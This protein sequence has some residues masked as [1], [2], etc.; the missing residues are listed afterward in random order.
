MNAIEDD[1][2]AIF[3]A[4]LE[5]TP[6]GRRNQLDAACG[7]NAELRARVDQL[8]DA[9]QAMG[10]IHGGLPVE[11]ATIQQRLEEGKGTLIGPYKLLE[12]IGEGGFGVVFLAEQER[13]VR[14]RV[15]L[16]IVKPGMDT[17]QVIARFEAERQALAMMDHPNI[18]KVLDAGTTVDRSLREGHG[19]RSEPATVETGRPYFVMELVKG[20]PITKYCD[21]HQHTIHQRVELFI[22]ICDGVQHAHQKGVIHRD[23]KPSNILV[24]EYDDRPVPKVIDFGV[25]KALSQSLTEKTMFTQFGQ[26]V[27][28]LDYMSPEQAKLNQLDVDTR[29][30]IYSL[31]VV[32]YELL[33]GLT[34][35]DKARLQSASFDEVL[36]IIAEE[37]APT[38]S[39]RVSMH[40]TLPTIAASRGIEP[41]KLS[42][43]LRGDLD[44][45][46]M[47]A[48]E[49]DRNR[50]YGTASSFAA[51]LKRYLTDEPVE[52]CPPTVR[53]RFA[54]FARRNRT[55][56]T[57]AALVALALV[58]GT[59]V[60]IWQACRATH[61]EIAAREDRDRALAAEAKEKA[62]GRILAIE[63]YI[64]AQQYQQAFDLLQEVEQILPEDPRLPELRT[65]CSWLV[66]VLTDPPG[67][68]VSRK[69][70]DG[71]EEIWEQLGLTPIKDRRLARGV[72]QWKSE[73]PGYRAAETLTADRP[74]GSS[75]LAL[76]LEV[77]LDAENVAPRDMVRVRPLAPGFFWPA[78][79]ITKGGI[80]IL[81]QFWMDRFEVT[82]RQFK[83]FVDQHGYR[84]KEFWEHPFEK[85]GEA[86]SWEEAVS[87]F[88]DTT[89]RP[90]PATWVN[91]TY[92]EGQDE[93]PV[94]GVSWYEAA[95]FAKFAGKSLPTIYDWN[96]ASGRAFMAEEIMAR[97]NLE[98]SGPVRV[99]H[100]RGLSH[101]GAYDMA[102]NVKEWC[103]NSAGRGRRYLLGAAWD[104]KNYMFARQGDA[105]APIEREKNMGFR[106]V[107]YLPEQP[108]P[109]AFEELE[110]PQR[111][112]AAETLLRDDEFKLVKGLY[113]YDNNKPLDAIVEPQPEAA[114]WTHERVTV[115]AAYGDEPLIVH[116]FLPKGT[117]PP[118][119]PVI[120]WP[121]ANAYFQPAIADLTA[122]KVAF[123]LKSGR[124]L[125]WP[126]Y[127]GSYERKVQPPLAANWQWQYVVQQ[128]NDLSRSI[129]YLQARKK[130]FDLDALGYYGYC[131]GAG[132]AVRALAVEDRIKAAVLVDGGLVSAA[133]YQRPE[134]DPVHY[135]PQITIPVLMLNGRFDIAFPPKESQEPMF[136]LLGTNL[137]RKRYRLSDTSHVSAL[138]ADRTDE[139]VSWFDQ[140]LGPVTRTGN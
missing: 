46:V 53:Y 108:P 95:A 132:H 33:T 131:W 69:H 1:A 34:P 71:V 123:L 83:E 26:L 49:K 59:G 25:A 7:D 73:K 136:R 36:R 50:R 122:E 112:F 96:G 54:K 121:G 37:D 11:P 40:D 32:L 24:A 19:S 78:G 140:Y 92:P 139:A 30:D 119:Q 17:R 21:E 87:L 6:D 86:L 5:C 91:G 129:D 38:P 18:A 111:D 82:N 15:A 68:M 70:P 80:S 51:D 128:A 113:A 23:L 105:R 52:A 31:G 93:Y 35:I 13:P 14:R 97:S 76:T 66:T 4:V 45:I 130:D 12:Q 101:C 22:Q 67:A 125:V 42:G 135:L 2:R 94:S 116:L 39:S 57:T 103:W 126:I 104:E 47:K 106:C 75:R 118:Y 98:G 100:Y 134:R 114:Y 56:L 41:E 77:D 74:P 61:A 9:H 3:L 43:V 64:K 138:T 65:E 62:H 72:Y 102:G 127:K 109:Q 48:L 10:S 117:A 115:D 79:Q 20:V 89:D 133:S 16:K 55:A 29:S 110:L 85:N 124:A 60:S 84:R 58:L 88:R 27:G 99:G 137:S 8:L 107:K 90:G 44:W 63:A 28:T 120:Y 81:P